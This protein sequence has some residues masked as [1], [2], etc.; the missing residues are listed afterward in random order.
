MV[1]LSATALDT[2]FGAL[3]DPT[4]RAILARLEA[5]DC[6]VSE[7]AAPFAMSLTAVAKHLRVLEAASLVCREKR[8]RVVT[9]RLEAA[10]LG[11]AAA[12]LRQ[13][14]RFWSG[15]LDQLARYAERK[16]DEATKGDR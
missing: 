2:T 8:G 5:R 4:R 7:L 1:Q 9:Y 10:R 14:E 3:A 6:A 16:E 11:D 13:Y 15:R 12:W